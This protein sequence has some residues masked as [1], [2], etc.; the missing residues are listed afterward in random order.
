M[1][2]VKASE[3]STIPFGGVL[4]NA[5]GAYNHVTSK[6]TAPVA[7]QYFFIVHADCSSD[8]RRIR[9]NVNGHKVFSA[10]NDGLEDHHVTGSGLVTLKAGDVVTASHYSSDGHLDAGHE[11]TFTGFL[12]K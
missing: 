9:V 2:S 1:P 8:Y 3:H 11:S 6:F 5:G 12:V 10:D 4:T 7:G